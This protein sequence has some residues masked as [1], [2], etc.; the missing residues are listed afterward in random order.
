MKT[1]Y[2]ILISILFVSCGAKNI[3]KMSG[4]KR[5]ETGIESRKYQDNDNEYYAIVLGEHGDEGE[6][7]RLSV[8]NASIEFA[9]KAEAMVNSAVKQDASQSINNK[10]GQLDIEAKRTIITK[11][12]TNNMT[13]VEDALYY[14][15]DQRIYKYRAVYKLDIEK[16]VK[17]LGG[18]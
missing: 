10:I 8:V 9:T 12:A 14:N 3:H 5:I 2:F 1:I 15:E 4:D 7:R 17:T 13:L 11:A 6:A 18:N 16:I